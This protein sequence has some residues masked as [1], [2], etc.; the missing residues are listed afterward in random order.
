MITPEFVRKRV[1]MEELQILLDD[2]SAEPIA[3]PKKA[4]FAVFYGYD[5]NQCSDIKAFRALLYDTKQW[6]GG[7]EIP[8]KSVLDAWAKSVAELCKYC[9]IRKDQ[10][11]DQTGP[12]GATHRGRGS[13]WQRLIAR[14][15]LVMRCCQ[16]WEEKVH[17]LG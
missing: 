9:G 8:D 16:M 4:I 2:R 12:S 6:V 15:R 1:P 14:L 3:Q 17:W 7:E 11:S 13:C 10:V 5:V